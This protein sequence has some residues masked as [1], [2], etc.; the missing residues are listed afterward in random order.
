MVLISRRLR[1]GLLT[2]CMMVYILLLDLVTPDHGYR[3][4]KLE[5]LFVYVD[6]AYVD[7]KTVELKC[8]SF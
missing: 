8:I 5:R 7:P 6:S 3:Y 1:E 2:S 4:K